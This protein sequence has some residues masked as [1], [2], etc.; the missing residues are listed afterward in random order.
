MN[1]SRATYA[2]VARQILA[3]Q[4]TP[5]SLLRK[6]PP[7]AHDKSRATTPQQ[8]ARLAHLT[9]RSLGA[10]KPEAR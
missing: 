2:P 3:R 8:R 1:P 5:P 7:V 4:I 10:R 9:V 6:L